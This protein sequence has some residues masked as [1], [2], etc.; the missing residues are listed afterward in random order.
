MV[1]PHL[2]EGTLG[3]HLDHRMYSTAIGVIGARA[4]DQGARECGRSLEAAN[5]FV[6]NDRVGPQDARLKVRRG[7]AKLLNLLLQPYAH[8]HA[9]AQAVP[10][11]RVYILVELIVANLTEAEHGEVVR[12]EGL[13]ASPSELLAVPL[14]ILARK[15]RIGPCNIVVAD[16]QAHRR[17]RN[18]WR[19]T[20]F[21][22]ALSGWR[23][24]VGHAVP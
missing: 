20:F 12:V 13:G 10:E 7:S 2:D 9:K 4:R 11:V 16:L 23:L 14:M 21:S 19:S 22:V 18:V 15:V 5:V 24:W 3:Q 6:Q 17:F 1:H 8:H